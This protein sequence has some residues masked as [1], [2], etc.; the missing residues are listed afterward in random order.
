MAKQ[1]INPYHILNAAREFKTAA[2]HLSQVSTQ[3]MCSDNPEE[4]SLSVSSLMSSIVLYAL[5][6]EVGL[7]SL[8]MLENNEYGNV[9]DLK[10][11]FNKLSEDSRKK[12]V[13]ELSDE[14]FKVDFDSY[15]EDNKKD[16]EDWRYY[17]EKTT[18]ANS[19]F[20]KAFSEAIIKV[21][22]SF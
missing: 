21:G 2:D 11:L 17:Y 16:F 9:H 13:E 20:L 12:I 22:E 4:N 19:D 15:L 7:K 3:Y 8:I 18:S 14:I 10:K 1:S 5:G 6:I